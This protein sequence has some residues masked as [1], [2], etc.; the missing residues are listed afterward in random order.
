MASNQHSPVRCCEQDFVLFVSHLQHHLLCL[1]TVR[2][3]Y[4][5]HDSS[6]LMNTT[7]NSVYELQQDNPVAH[8]HTCICV[9]M[10]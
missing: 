5:S 8:A 4:N 2:L 10:K 6:C 1:T 9:F 3:K 7:G